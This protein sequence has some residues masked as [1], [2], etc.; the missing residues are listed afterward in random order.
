VTI[1]ADRK[2]VIPD[3][4]RV[5]STLAAVS[6]V[7]DVH[8]DVDD[9]ARPTSVRLVLD[10]GVDE[11]VVALAVHRALHLE[12][13]PGLGHV[14]LE[15][16]DDGSADGRRPPQHLRPSGSGSR[17]RRSPARALLSGRPDVFDVEVGPGVGQAP[18]A[19]IVLEDD[20]LTASAAVEPNADAEP[21]LEAP[22]PAPTPTD[23][24]SPPAR[25]GSSAV[26]VVADAT[27]VIASVTLTRDDVELVGTSQLEASAVAA[28]RSVSFATAR[29]LTA[30][31][32]ATLRALDGVVGDGV[33]LHV[34]SVSL[35]PVG[36]ARVAIA[37]VFWVSPQGSQRLTG[38]AEVDDDAR[39]AMVRA[40]VDAVNRRLDPPFLLT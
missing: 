28:T 23:P 22:A 34:D 38:S 10:P 3:P 15:V 12:F 35:T 39:S 4:A 13:G 37:Q 29:A 16:L 20:P 19:E 27:G 31:A 25:P 14:R 32:A 11:T 21:T 1:G 40:T 9:V 17:A 2:V 7:T 36:V 30:V 8:V 18:A 5:R 24:G 26:T 33:R 6:G